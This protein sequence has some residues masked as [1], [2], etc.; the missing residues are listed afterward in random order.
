[1]LT[2]WIL[3]AFLMGALAWRIGLPPLVGFLASGFLFGALGA[4]SNELLEV[5]ADAGVLL[6][7]FAVGLKLRFRTLI[8]TEVWGSATAH[9]L[10]I[11]LVAYLSVGL[12]TEFGIGVAI[13]A[14]IA[15][16][17][18]STVLAAKVLESNYELRSVHGRIAIGV[19]IIQD[20][21][22]VAVL[23]AI[24][25]GTPSPWA[26]GLLALPLLRPIA[27]WILD[28]VGHEE[29]LVLFGAVLAIVVGGTGFE[30]L[31]LSPELGALVMGVMLAGHRRS[32][33]L[34]NALWGLKEFFLV[35][36]FLSI[37][38]NG[39]PTLEILISAAWLLLFIPVKAVVLS[40]LLIALGLR[41]RTSFL[42]GLSLATYSEFGLIITSV[43]V[44]NGLLPPEWLVVAAVLVA[45][46]FV[47]AAPL[48][49]YAHEIFEHL[50]GFLQ[51]FERDTAHYDDE[52]VSLGT[53]RLLIVGM[54]RVGSGAYDHFH[55]QG[56][57]VVGMDADLGKV[58]RS[59][60]A[61]R[62][63]VYADAEDSGFWQQLN[64]DHIRL[65]MLALP[66][67]HATCFAARVL[68][69]RGF[70][71]VISATYLY[72]EDQQPMLKAGCDVTYNYF[73]EAGV[74]FA[75]D[76]AEVLA[77]AQDR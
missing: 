39:T 59:R 45:A 55:R 77:A 18:S 5:L 1:L 43:A 53:S 41:A 40:G 56:E 6:L 72:P 11:G 47:I 54:G 62:R 15:L 22:A 50:A 44:N 31:N 9:L 21:V 61:G 65:V 51:R 57:H 52:P 16:S 24:N 10:I 2:T 33:E 74:G 48:N 23:A 71:G 25:G 35:G 28:A 64:I 29:L 7:L 26:L 46:S 14:A 27:G 3:A 68:R 30:L 63:V 49:T 67:L 73:T 12:A 4:E 58:E 66:D 69:S 36:F 17:F 38:F 37:G 70:R 76:T 60:A 8:R 34:S 42:T 19:L 20:I 75:R 32:Q 13:M